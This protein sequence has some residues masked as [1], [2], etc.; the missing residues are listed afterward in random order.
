MT[1][2][3]ISYDFYNANSIKKLLNLKSFFFKL[4]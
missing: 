3:N 4:N 2:Q 1:I